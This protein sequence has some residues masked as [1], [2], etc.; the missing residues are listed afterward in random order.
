LPAT[1]ALAEGSRGGPVAFSRLRSKSCVSGG[2]E[3]ACEIVCMDNARA[4]TSNLANLLRREHAALGEFVVALADFDRRRIWVDLG[5][6]SLF[7]FLHRELRLSKAA[8][9]YRKVAAELVQR[10]PAAIEP[11]RDGRLCLTSIIEAAKVVTPENVETVLPRFFG[12]SRREA[13]EIVAEL[14]PHPSPP[15]RTVVT[16]PR[17][18]AARD[19]SAVDGV[20]DDNSGSARAVAA[21]GSPDELTLSEVGALCGSEGAR[22]GFVGSPDE[23]TRSDAAVALA[24][25]APR[26]VEI[27]PLTAEE[28]RLHITVSVRLLRKLEAAAAALSHS[29]PGAPAEAILEAGLDLLLAQAEKRR[30]AVEKP[31]KAPRPAKANHVP[32]QVR[33]AVWARDGGKCQWPLASGGICG[34]TRRLQVDHIQ[35][36]ALGGRS[37]IENVRLLCREHNLFA[38]RRAL[39][40][41][42]MDR[43]TTDPRAPR[44]TADVR[45]LPRPA[46]PRRV[47]VKTAR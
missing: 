26:P 33:R 17:T 2:L 12:L 6:T 13:M 44:P 30:G 19:A 23:L 16:S 32:A 9:Q 45:E 11:L 15:T 38:A 8:A 27:V 46:P 4:L 31:L 20:V 21:T 14:Q 39:G 7:Y 28:R 18:A 34:C 29:H 25:A 35:P 5:Y 22:K 24:S 40:D 36:L 37:T 41:A 43:Y 47:R 3:N 42:L 1:L 10:I